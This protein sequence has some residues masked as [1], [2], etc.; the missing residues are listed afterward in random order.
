LY[1][2]RGDRLRRVEVIVAW[3]NDELVVASGLIRTWCWFRG[4]SKA[5]SNEWIVFLAVGIEILLLR[6]LVAAG[7]R[8][9]IWGYP[10]AS[11]AIEIGLPR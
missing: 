3:G 5:R 11:H 4:R 2:L 10:V 8:N 7:R 6:C 1:I 9:S